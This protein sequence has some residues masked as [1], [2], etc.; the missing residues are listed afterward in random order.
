MAALRNLLYPFLAFLAVWP[1]H[2]QFP[3]SMNRY[4][5]AATGSD[6]YEHILKP[7]NVNPSAFG[8]LYSYQVNGAVY[9]QPL[10]L[11]DVPIA[12]HGSV[13]VLYVATMNDKLYALN[14][15]KPGTPL[16]VRSFVPARTGFSPIPII[17]IT[18][19][20]DL[21]IVGNVGIEGTPA[22]DAA[23]NA[24]FLVARTR[25]NGRYFDRLYKV[26][27]R[28]GKDLARPIAIEAGVPGAAKDALD[29]VL[30]FD[31]KS[32]N[33]RAS[34][35]LVGGAVII[36]WG[37]HE[38][39]PPYHGWV[40]AYDAQTL[41]QRGA[42]CVTPDGAAGGVWQSGRGPAVDES[43]NIYFETGNGDWDGRRNFG[44]SLV[45][46]NLTGSGLEAQDYF[47]PA[48]YQQLNDHDADSVL[49]DPC[50]SLARDF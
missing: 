6:P 37:S 35:A 2:A 19:C 3:V 28:T 4:D 11:A 43:D 38:D 48:D 18:N 50:C 49:P 15:D 25:E 44:T 21:N 13:N 47:T 39:L 45:K 17:D 31:P 36:A 46:L 20:N 8:K 7:S 33:Q 32:S 26:D 5:R 34:L 41:R 16:W 24:L 22:I 12:G 14:A 40:I 1:A 27:V 9:A 23:S 30:R 29:G 10:Y 42:W